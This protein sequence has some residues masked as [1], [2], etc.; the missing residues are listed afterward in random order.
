M[1]SF[2]TAT[3]RYDINVKKPAIIKTHLD[4]FIAILIIH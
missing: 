1:L 2:A 3:V 4:V